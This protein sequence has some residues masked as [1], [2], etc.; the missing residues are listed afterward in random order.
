MSNYRTKILVL[1]TR[2]LGEAD[3]IILGLSEDYGKFEAVVKG[4]RRQRSRFVGNT[5][6]FNVLNALFFTGKSLDQL[7]QAELVRSF[8]TIREDL[9]KMAYGT[10]WVELVAEFLPERDPVP[11]IF[12][13]LLAALLTLEVSHC[14]ELL[15]LA[16]QMRLLNYL[17]YEPQLELCVNCGDRISFPARFSV[18]AG[19]VICP[20]CFEA[21]QPQGI[22][23]HHEDLQALKTLANTDIR[24]LDGRT[25]AILNLSLIK[26]LLRGFIEARLDHPLKSQAF[27]ESVLLK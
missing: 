1:K 8:S 7:S 10:F 14:P 18:Q 3:R 26:N 23:I 24:K 19:G 27:L 21:V 2:K 16:F 20:R 17:G 11:E 6:P 4:A 5:L 13:F 15:N 12:R 25:G 22:V 9:V